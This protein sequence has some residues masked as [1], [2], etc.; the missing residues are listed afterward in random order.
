MHLTNSDITTALLIISL[1]ISG[2]RWAHG[3]AGKR[4]SDSEGLSG[5]RKMIEDANARSSEKHSETMVRIY[6]LEQSVTRLKALEEARH[7]HIR[8]ED[9]NS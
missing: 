7:F 2:L 1:L 5:I 4:E 3:W 8:K 9:F 6:D